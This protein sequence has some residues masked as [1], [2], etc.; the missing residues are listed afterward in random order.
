MLNVKTLSELTNDSGTILDDMHDD[1]YNDSEWPHS[2]IH[3]GMLVQPSPGHKEFHI[4]LDQSGLVTKQEGEMFEVMWNDNSIDRV[5]AYSLEPLYD[6][7]VMDK[8]LRHG[9][10]IVEAQ[11]RG[12]WHSL[13]KNSGDKQVPSALDNPAPRF[14]VGS[15]VAAG[16][17]HSCNHDYQGAGLVV[18]VD[19]S[20]V[21]S[22]YFIH[23]S[24]GSYWH[25]E[26]DLEHYDE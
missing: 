22:E 9:Y 15:L 6:R 3:E 21:P 19:D 13:D 20:M 18:E 4:R 2:I 17:G 7:E 11:I 24:G 12:D 5:T 10:G 1:L 8:K 16:Y 23:W 25:T 14:D 26:D